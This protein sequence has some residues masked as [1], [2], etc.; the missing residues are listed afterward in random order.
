MVVFSTETFTHKPAKPARMQLQVEKIQ[1]YQRLLADPNR[2]PERGEAGEGESGF[3]DL[4]FKY[5]LRVSIACRGKHSD[6]G[7]RGC[8]RI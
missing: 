3:G 4:R 1:H 8:S 7:F 2:E 6:S 5:E